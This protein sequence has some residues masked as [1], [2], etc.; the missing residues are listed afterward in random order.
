[1]NNPP[2]TESAEPPRALIAALTRLLAPL[3]RLLLAHGVTYPALIRLL[4]S[5]YVDVAD[6][7]FAMD[8][9][10]QSDSRISLLTGVH[11]KDVRILRGQ[12]KDPQGAPESV[13]LGSQL[14]ARWVGERRY[15]DSDGRPRALPRRSLRGP[16]FD[17]LAA[18]VSRQDVKPRVVLDE[19]LRLGLVEITDNDEV[20]LKVEAFVPQRGMEEKFYYFGRNLADHMAAGV[21]NL[22]AESPPFIERAVSYHNLRA[23]DINTLR[24]LVDERGMDT[25]KA[26][27]RKA[28]SLRK[29]SSGKTDAEQ[30]MIFGVYF[31]SEAQGDSEKDAL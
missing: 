4:K 21:S 20:R 9:R 24:A 22:Q 7:H 13:T 12:S 17:A 27:N 25:L 2:R 26:V 3:V 1:M 11:R 23:A 8:D 15:L 19:L 5:V 29:H 10:P 28:I 30:R 16:S 18:S 31:Y 14:I 6:Q